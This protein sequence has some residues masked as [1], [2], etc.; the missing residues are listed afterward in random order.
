MGDWNLGD[1]LDIVAGEVP[2]S[3]ALIQGA[4]RVLWRALDR[5][6]GAARLYVEALR[7]TEGGRVW[8]PP[9][10][11]ASEPDLDAYAASALPSP[12]QLPASREIRT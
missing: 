5:R 2:D 1:V 7:G 3:P 10:A 9:P 6:A 4:R 11:G 8:P 12:A